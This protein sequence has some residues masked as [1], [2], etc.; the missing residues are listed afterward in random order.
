MIRKSNE[1]SV[2][3]AIREFLKRYRL[4]NKLDEVEVMH[5][6]EEIAGPMVSNYT[7]NLY[8]R[9]KTLYISVD[10]AALRNELNMHRTKIIRSLNKKMGKEVID[11]VV[12]K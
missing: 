6:W 7:K 9:H 11:N 1:Q 5:L 8:V 10:S 2:G 3:E 12:F 4:E